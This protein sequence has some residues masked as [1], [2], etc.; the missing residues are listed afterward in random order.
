M[1]IGPLQG[2]KATN[3]VGLQP[4]SVEELLA[5][6]EANR[7]KDPAK[8]QE[9]ASS[10]QQMFRGMGNLGG[11]G[12]SPELKQALL[13]ASGNSAINPNAVLQR[14]TQLGAPVDAVSGSAPK[15]DARALSRGRNLDV[16]TAGPGLDAVA[17]GSAVL[18]RGHKGE[19]VKELQRMLNA[20]GANLE[21]D[22]KLGPKT[23]AALKAFQDGRGLGSNG[24]LD[25]STLEMLRKGGD[26]LA[27]EQWAKFAPDY[28]IDRER[29][30]TD[31]AEVRFER[32]KP[33]DP[34]ALESAKVSTGVDGLLQRIAE[35]EGT[36]DAK[37]RKHGY[38]PGATN[39]AGKNDA[40]YEVTLSYGAYVPE[41][42]KGKPLTE[43]SI[44]EVRNLQRGM[45]DHPR[46]GWNSSAVG[47]YQIVG[48]TL[49]GLL[50]DPKIKALG[51][52]RNTQFTP[53]VQDILGKR[54]LEQR[55]LGSFQ[56]GRMSAT[57]FQNSLAHEWASVAHSS[58]G[59]SVYGQG[60]GTTTS[61]IRAAIAGVRE[62]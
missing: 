60:T 42:L 61:Q 16:Y 26:K 4:T 47:K 14:L 9:Y 56:A 10:I 24:V 17:S 32:A 13:S 12:L 36:S 55:G 35:G 25:A 28:G 52:D 62:A 23:E 33:L 40:G 48:K 59:T 3:T 51:I 54:L 46:N 31:A 6:I 7:P 19:G 27:P 50:N 20:M 11:A 45:L 8:Q 2:S 30:K 57:E 38:T 58:S 1:S 5:L 21:V 49:E 15:I 29:A 39:A 22:G 53:E 44:A 34:G 41:H 37:A 18:H 43:M